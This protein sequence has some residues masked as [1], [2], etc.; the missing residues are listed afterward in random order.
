MISQMSV[1]AYHHSYVLTLHASPSSSILNV[2]LPRRRAP[3]PNTTRI[4]HHDHADGRGSRARSS[5]SVGSTSTVRKPSR[6]VIRFWLSDECQT[7]EQAG[8]QRIQG[9]MP[10]RLG[11]VRA[12]QAVCPVKPDESLS[13]LFQVVN[14][15]SRHRPRLGCTP[16]PCFGE[17]G[18]FVRDR[19]P[20]VGTHPAPCQSAT[21]NGA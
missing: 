9:L 20:R 18:H 17:D 2:L 7:I 1:S 19:R 16:P 8:T 14:P 4:T 21:R 12:R 10:L 13:F 15:R 3:V 6:F 11:S 5:F